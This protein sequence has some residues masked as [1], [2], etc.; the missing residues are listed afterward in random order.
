MLHCLNG[1]TS[2]QSQMVGKV[3]VTLIGA[4]AVA[5]KWEV[6]L[7]VGV[8]F[9]EPVVARV[10]GT[11][12]P[13]MVVKWQVAGKVVG[14]LTRWVGDKSVTMNVD[15]NGPVVTRVDGT[16]VSEIV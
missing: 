12:V 4:A 3:L 8:N 7:K 15:F 2:G 1:V 9:N 14:E 11:F 16:F 5:E 10:N 6:A 13:E